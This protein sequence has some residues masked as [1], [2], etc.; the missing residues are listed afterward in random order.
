VERLGRKG[1][2]EAMARCPTRQDAEA[3]AAWL[4][5]RISRL[6]PDLAVTTEIEPGGGQYLLILRA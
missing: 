1:G 2:R 6:A 5:D 3:A 4:L